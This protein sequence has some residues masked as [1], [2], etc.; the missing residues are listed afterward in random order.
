MARM[1]ITD[2]LIEIFEACEDLDFSTS[3]LENI[4]SGNV[5][6]FK[7][8]YELKDSIKLYAK[9]LGLDPNKVVDEFNGFLFQH[10]SR[11]SLDDIKA[12]QKKSDEEKNKISSPYTMEYKEKF[13][14]WP[15]IYSIIGI[16][17]FIIVIYLV[18]SN[19][20][21][22]PE[23]VDELRSIIEKEELIYEFANKDY[24]C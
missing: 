18:I 13:N 11:I 4:E 15:I 6:A 22:A 5:R 20:N 2:E 16:V 1:E 3:H 23:R 12:A 17:L 24:C 9:Y 10:T 21:K 7:D 19:T 14:F 8:V